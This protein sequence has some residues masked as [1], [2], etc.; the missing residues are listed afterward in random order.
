[1]TKVKIAIE[2]P[3]YCSTSNYYSNEASEHYDTFEEFYE[4]W[5]DADIDMN[6]IFR[7]DVIEDRYD[8]DK[9][10]GTYHAYIFIMLQR[11]GI[12]KPITIDRFMPEDEPKAIELLRKHWKQIKKAWKPIS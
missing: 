4:N 8:N 7:F 6:L 5:H 9:P 10:K 1:M 12:F 11:K 2:H 3:Y